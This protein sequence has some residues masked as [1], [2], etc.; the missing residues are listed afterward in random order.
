MDDKLSATEAP[1]GKVPIEVI[2]SVG[3]AR[4]RVCDLLALKGDAVLALD[5]RVE[6]PVELFIGDELIATGE[7]IE[8]EGE[9]RGRLGVRLIEV[10]RRGGPV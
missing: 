9:E 8:L 3:R 2:V 1:F 5:R 4:P 6:D 10:R 7:L